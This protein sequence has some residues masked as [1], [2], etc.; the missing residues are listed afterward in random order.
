MGAHVEPI[1]LSCCM[2][3]SANAVLLLSIAICAKPKVLWPFLT[4]S[5]IV[6]SQAGSS[7]AKRRVM[8]T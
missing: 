3:I 6:L 5:A 7:S 8:T 1:V 2:A 4:S